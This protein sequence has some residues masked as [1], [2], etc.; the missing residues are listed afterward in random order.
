MKANKI[1]TTKSHVKRDCDFFFIVGTGRSG[2][3]LMAQVMNANSKI[4]VPGEL[5]IAFEYSNNGARLAEVFSSKD[6]LQFQAKDYIKLV[7]QRCPHNL[8]EYYDYR[9]FFQQRDYPIVSLKELLTEFYTDIAYSQGKSIF[10]EQTPWYGQNI[11]LLSELFP[12]AKFIH[13]VRD[14][15]DV[16]ISFART[17]WW[18]NDV[19]LNL[20]RWEKE[21]NKIENDGAVILN[22]RMLTIRYEDLI[23]E[24]DEIVKGACDFLDVPFEKEMLDSQYHIDYKQFGK[25]NNAKILSPEY[26]RWEKEK[27]SAFFSGSVYNW[28]TNKEFDFKALNKPIMETLSRFGYDVS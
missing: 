3:T 11:E 5:Q 19:N 24:P 14:G 13:M 4:C 21:V 17:P 15:R 18:H 10:A 2:T 6:N 28:K 9:T 7:Q 23:S 22:G 27:K 25:I 20:E 8:Q 12:Q 26:K 1:V 16:A